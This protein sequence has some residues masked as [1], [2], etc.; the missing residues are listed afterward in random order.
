MLPVYMGEGRPRK[1]RYQTRKGDSSLE[2][3]LS[4]FVLDRKKEPLMPC[5]EKGQAAADCWHL[6]R[7]THPC[8][9]K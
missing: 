2:V 5:S 8:L 6:R 3:N 4:V 7:L 9:E 1:G